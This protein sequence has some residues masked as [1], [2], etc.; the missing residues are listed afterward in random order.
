MKALNR[1]V[2]ALLAAAVFPV[3]YFTDL[4]TV[5]MHATIYDSNIVENL[6][7]KRIIE[8]F[9]GDGLFAGL[10]KDGSEIPTDFWSS[11]AISSPL[12][13]AL[14]LPCSSRSRQ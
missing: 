14:L 9:T 11:R 12:P 7:V 8:L 3:A 5:Y 2:T 1:I 13:Y 4:I 6:S 10:I